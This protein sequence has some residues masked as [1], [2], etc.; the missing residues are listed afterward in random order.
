MAIHLYIKQLRR[1]TV[2][3]ASLSLVFDPDVCLFWS[4]THLG[5]VNKSAVDLILEI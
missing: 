4:W 5:R 3:F 2:Y 1:K